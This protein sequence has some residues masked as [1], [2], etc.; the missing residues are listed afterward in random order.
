MTYELGFG[1]KRPVQHATR[2]REPTIIEIPAFV[3]MAMPL[4]DLAQRIADHQD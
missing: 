3:T 2:P 4:T 1:T